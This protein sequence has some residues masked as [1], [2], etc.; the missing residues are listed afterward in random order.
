MF[1]PEKSHARLEIWYR[2]HPTPLRRI[3]EV[4][5]RA[6]SHFPVLLLIRIICARRKRNAGLRYHSMNLSD[7]RR[8]YQFAGLR[9]AQLAADPLVQFE[10]WFTEA[11]QAA[12]V[13]PNAMTLATVAADGQPSARVVLLKALDARGFHFFT[14]FESQKGR[15]LEKNPG[16][17]LVFLW[18]ELERQVRVEGVA[19]RL[20][21]ERSAA[22]F[23]SRPR[24]SQLSA[25]ASTQ[26]VVIKTRSE[27]E[28]KYIEVAARFADGEVPLPPHWGGYA[29]LPQR[30]EFWQGRPGRLHD[31]FLYVRV[32]N[33]WRIERLAP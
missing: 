2:Y 11:Q 25:W 3:T 13:E 17:A 26:S 15:E 31:R 1:A 29:L 24:E 14:N 10:K 30:I 16:A 6:F 20:D 12:V 27:L 9:R 8:N 32:E 22:Y 23:H 18:K 19:S 7:L 21:P 33:G 28:A 4:L 5:F